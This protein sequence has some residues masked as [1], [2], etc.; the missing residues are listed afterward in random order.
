MLLW[1]TGPAVGPSPP[2]VA[3]AT[4][5]VTA[6]RA[7][8]TVRRVH[9]A[10]SRRPL[11]RL[12]RRA[13]LLVA[14]LACAALLPPVVV[15]DAASPGD[16]LVLEPAVLRVAVGTATVRVALGTDAPGPL[17]VDATVVDADLAPDGVVSPG[18]AP[19][20]WAAVAGAT[21]P[22]RPGEVLELP[23]VVREAPADGVAA[24]VVRGVPA[25]EPRSNE[26]LPAPDGEAVEVVAVLLA[27]APAGELD[28]GLERDGGVARVTVRAA[29]PSLVGIAASA[30]G[31]T[32]EAADRVVV[33]GTPTVVEL[34]LPGQP[35]P[36]QVEVVDDAGA[37]ATA[38]L[39][40]PVPVLAVAVLL[41]VLAAVGLLVLVV[42]RRR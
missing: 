39:G 26:L 3:G 36:L 17:L 40:P 23:V 6:V 22:L 33:P 30:R 38:Q 32:R 27:D 18:D 25:V 20:G 35:W 34:E 11:P 21:T 15:D 41:L 1:S 9:A 31:V 19:P 37:R 2:T 14:L 7:A 12:L 13:G 4:R 5:H 42:R 16:D 24:V 28:F 10:P 8:R 29:R